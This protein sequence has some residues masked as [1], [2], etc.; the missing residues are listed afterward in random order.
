M[1]DRPALHFESPI[2]Q[3]IESVVKSSRLAKYVRECVDIAVT[4]YAVRREDD[5]SRERRP[6]LKESV[7]VKAAEDF[8]GRFEGSADDKKDHVTH[9]PGGRV[10]ITA[11]DSWS[12]DGREM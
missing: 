1:A 12:A 2:L 6:Y 10:Y 9:A 5:A 7:S 3:R 11:L 8:W 4:K